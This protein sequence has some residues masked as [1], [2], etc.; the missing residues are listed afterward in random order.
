MKRLNEPSLCIPE[1]EAVPGCGDGE[2]VVGRPK[3]EGGQEGL[4]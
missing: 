3:D 1:L 4:L 2:R